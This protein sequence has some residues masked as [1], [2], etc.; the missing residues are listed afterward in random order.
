MGSI[1]NFL[2]YR[3]AREDNCSHPWG[4]RPLLS[5]HIA[6]WK[7]CALPLKEADV[8]SQPFPPTVPSATFPSL[9]WPQLINQSI[10][11][12]LFSESL[13]GVRACRKGVFRGGSGCGQTE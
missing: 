9:A 4:P 3:M 6:E 13:A 7:Q 11:G 2:T 8:K 5:R 10:W 1:V 12:I